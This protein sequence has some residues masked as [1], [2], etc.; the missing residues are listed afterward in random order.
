MTKYIGI[1]RAFRT[2]V[3]AMSILAA[4]CG[5]NSSSQQAG[6]VGAKSVVN[7]DPK[8]LLAG[9]TTGIQQTAARSLGGWEWGSFIS[10][11]GTLLTSISY[12]LDMQKVT[13]QSTGA[14]GLA[15]TMTGLLILPRSIFGAKPSVPILMYQHGTE[16][17]RPYSPSRFLAH[18]DRPTDYPEV[19]V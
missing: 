17:F 5:L 18:L 7:I 9:I 8:V 6:A 3:V 19:M 2:T 4:G 11:F 15:H 13:Y 1:K 12:T 16:P 14:D 10:S